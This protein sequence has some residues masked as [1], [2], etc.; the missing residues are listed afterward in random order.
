[1]SFG[2]IFAKRF[3]ANPSR[4]ASM[5]LSAILHLLPWAGVVSYLGGIL[6]VGH[7]LDSRLTPAARVSFSKFVQGTD[8]SE[9][10]RSLPEIANQSLNRIFGNNHFTIKCL[11]RSILFSLLSLLFLAALTL[12][13]YVRLINAAT[14]EFAK[15]LKAYW[16]I[17]NDKGT[18][19]SLIS[20]VFISLIVDYFSLYKTR[21][22]IEY[23][24]LRKLTV[25]FLLLI[26][27]IDFVVGFIL[28]CLLFTLFAVIGGVVDISFIPSPAFSFETMFL[29][30][31]ISLYFSYLTNP[32]SAQQLNNQAQS[33]HQLYDLL[34]T[35]TGLAFIAFLFLVQLIPGTTVGSVFFYTSMMPSIWLWIFFVT[36]TV[37]SA[38]KLFVLANSF[39][40]KYL[41]IDK[42]TTEIYAIFASLCLA[43]IL[44]V[45]F[46]VIVTVLFL[47]R[48]LGFTLT[49]LLSHLHNGSYGQ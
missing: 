22:I 14:P 29:F 26:A 42:N 37:A 23:C 32:E 20:W 48:T 40:H 19:Y 6:A 33:N 13:T 30:L 9:T 44:V 27:I 28:Y 7:W 49:Y 2:S 25:I 11:L 10:I 39:I 34:H 16:A 38:L 12:V 8:F 15:L 21:L 47:E 4:G 1:M 31:A 5:V 18:I 36:A 24:L 3:D 46:V 43:F 41:T 35:Q 17:Y 45:G